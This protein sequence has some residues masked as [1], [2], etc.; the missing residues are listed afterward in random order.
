MRKLCKYS[1]LSVQKVCEYTYNIVYIRQIVVILALICVSNLPLT[2]RDVII[3]GKQVFI[4][5][6]CHFV[7]INIARTL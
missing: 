1:N 3:S 7:I 4:S 6:D 5:K 2:C